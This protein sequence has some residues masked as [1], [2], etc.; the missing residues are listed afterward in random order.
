ML[1]HIE[2]SQ[3]IKTPAVDLKKVAKFWAHH[4]DRSIEFTL[5]DFLVINSRRFD[6]LLMLDVIEHFCQSS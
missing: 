5:D 1:N 4:S 2:L 6:L 3:Q